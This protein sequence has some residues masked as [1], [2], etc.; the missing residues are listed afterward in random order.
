M[1][2]IYNKGIVIGFDPDSYS[3]NETDGTVMLTVRVFEG[4][5]SEGRSIPVRVTTSDDS[6]QGKLL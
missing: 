6:A 1:Y 4:T 3:V 2:C 5:I